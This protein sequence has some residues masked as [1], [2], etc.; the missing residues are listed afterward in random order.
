MTEIT[1]SPKW[2][3]WPLSTY[4]GILTIIFYFNFS[5]TA[6]IIY[7]GP[8][9][10]LDNWLSDLGAIALNP[11]GAI[12]YNVGCMLTGIALVF[13]FIGFNEIKA[14]VR[15]DKIMLILI[16]LFGYGCAVSVF[17][18]GVYPGEFVIEHAVF[19]VSIFAFLQP[20]YIIGS[21]FISRW[22]T[23]SRF[24]KF[25]VVYGI[26]I[27]IFNSALLVVFTLSIL[28]V[29][30]IHI[31]EWFAIWSSYGFTGQIAYLFYAESKSRD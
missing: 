11:N 4:S 24:K 27:T 20:V 15:M 28:D 17:F 22:D 25:V 23:S 2:F 5:I 14:D 19:S 9:T 13:F 31:V 21:I 3:K 8:Y 16:Q 30:K 26:I 7:I 18:I 10:P 6:M 29:A 12:V 1:I